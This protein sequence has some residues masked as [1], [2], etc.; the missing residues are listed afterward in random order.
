M[1]SKARI[2]EWYKRLEEVHKDVEINEQ[3]GRP[4]HQ[5]PMQTWKK[6][7]NWV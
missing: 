4:V 6:L 3:T 7:Q 2:Y 1:A 5:Q